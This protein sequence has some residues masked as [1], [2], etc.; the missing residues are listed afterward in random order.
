M[1]ILIVD[2]NKSICEM[3]TTLFQSQGYDVK[4]SSDGL[5]AIT[6]AVDYVPDIVLLDIL[7][8][9]MNGYQFLDA[10]KVNTSMDPVVIILSN[11]GEQIEI[12][13]AMQ[14]GADG[15]LQKSDYTGQV[16]VD[17]VNKLYTEALYRRQATKQ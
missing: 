16:L 2:D 4:T 17:A 10:L 11:L 1:K 12:D 7:M 14:H 8:P 13:R 3:Y 5:T 6:D 15:Y 9:E